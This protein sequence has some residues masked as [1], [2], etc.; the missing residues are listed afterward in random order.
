M[1]S[2][3]QRTCNN[4]YL[5]DKWQSLYWLLTFPVRNLEHMLEIFF[6]GL[7][8]IVN[9]QHNTGGGTYID[10]VDVSMKLCDLSNRK[11]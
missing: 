7:P 1:S 10:G 3:C 8:K 9:C 11:H 6:H 5:Y 4:M 2:E